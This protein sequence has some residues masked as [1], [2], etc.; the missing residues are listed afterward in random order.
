MC[1]TSRHEA[2]EGGYHCPMRGYSLIG[3][4]VS[5]AMLLVLGVVMSNAINKATT[6][7]GSTL[8][9]TVRSFQDK[10]YLVS[11]YQTLVVDAQLSGNRRFL[12]PSALTRRLDVGDDTTANLF[13]AMVAQHSIPP[14]QM[15]SGNEM[16]PYVK[17]DEDY[18][19]AAYSA[20]DDTYWDPNFAA[21][22]TW[23]SNTSFAHPPL[24]GNRLRRYWHAGVD[25][26][27]PLLGNRGPKDGV[28]NPDSW[29][30]NRDGRW[31]GH[32]VFGD[33][34]VEFVQTFTINGIFLQ[35]PGGNEP[36]NLFRMEQGADGSDVI[37]TFTKQMTADG[38]VLQY[39]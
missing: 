37:L 30:Y 38:P 19:Y 6:G 25:S 12:V 39:D 7:A 22:L 15:I 9:G 18:N 34:H 11:I 5:M 2:T 13:S 28:A 36:D 26:R 29:T 21:D 23:E 27:T 35:G 24:Y 4:L 33:G 17:L 10:Q 31:A 8:S 14:A 16:S 32:L 3:L 20:T 1:G